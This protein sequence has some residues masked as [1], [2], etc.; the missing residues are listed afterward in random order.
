[1]GQFKTKK[2]RT[3]YTPPT[4]VI[5]QDIDRHWQD[6]YPEFL[7]E[8]DLLA[9]KGVIVYHSLTCRDEV[10]VEAGIPDSKEY[11]LDKNIKVKAFVKK[12]N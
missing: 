10:Y 1:M 7:R 4:S 3:G 5:S 12:G 8:G 9:G 11:L 2:A 6:V